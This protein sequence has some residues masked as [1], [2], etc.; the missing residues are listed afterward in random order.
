MKERNSE[1]LTVENVVMGEEAGE[2]S[3]IGQ[4]S[5]VTRGNTTPFNFEGSIQPYKL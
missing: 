1:S 2:V 4:A 5:T 3:E